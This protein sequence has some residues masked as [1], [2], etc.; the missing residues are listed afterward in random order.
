LENDDDEGLK[1]LYEEELMKEQCLRL[2]VSDSFF[3]K[4]NNCEQ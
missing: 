4:K 3:F 2:G 1:N